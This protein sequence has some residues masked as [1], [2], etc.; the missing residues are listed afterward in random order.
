MSSKEKIKLVQVIAD[1]SLTGGPRHVLGLIKHLDKDKYNILLIAP[2][3]WLTAEATKISGVK[4]KIVDFR[5]KF[6]LNSLTKLKKDIAEFRSADNPFGPIIIHAHGPRAGYFLALAKRPSEKFIY[7]EHIW[8]HEYKIENFINRKL[9]SLGIKFTCHRADLVIAVSKSVKNFLLKPL[10]VIEKKIIIIPN[11]IEVND[12]NQ[13]GKI[14]GSAQLLI[15]TIGALV[16]RKGHIH[17][18]RAFLRVAASLPKARLEIIGDGPE[19]QN[20]LNEI[21]KLGLESKIQL[22]GEQK[23]TEKFLNSWNLFVLPSIS[24]VFGIVILEAFEARVPVVATAVGGVPEIIKND[25]NG[26]LVPASDPKKLAKAILYLLV[27]KQERQKLADSAYK[28]LKER[29]DWSKIIVDI[30][31]QYEKVVT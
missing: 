30:E 10:G 19:K 14:N 29:Y 1:S 23:N 12:K 26:I 5:S 13:D 2:R 28:I 20:L 9:Q 15:G 3:G 11:A 18:I 17:L 7:S 6:D 4:V 31:K 24:E 16:K 22:V 8:S 25:E 21:K 27:E